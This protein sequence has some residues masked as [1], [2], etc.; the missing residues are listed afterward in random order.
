M[1]KCHFSRALW[2]SAVSALLVFA[3]VRIPLEGDPPQ[4][5]VAELFDP[6]L[7]AQR[8][9]GGERQWS[10]IAQAMASPQPNINARSP[11]LTGLGDYT[12]KITTASLDAQAFFDQGL[13]LIYAFNPGEAA[14][15]FRSASDKDPTCAMC[16]W[17]E[18]LGLGGNLNGGMNQDNM[19][20]ALAAVKKA[21]ENAPHVTPH[22][23]ALIGALAE[24]YSADKT[25]KPQ[26]LDL[27]Y[28]DA[29]AKVYATYSDD[30]DI[31]D[32]SAD[33]AMQVRSDPWGNWWDRTRTHPTGYLARAITALEK[34]LARYPDHPGAIHLYIHAM[35]G[36]L[37]PERAEPYADKLS[38]L[39]PGAGHMV[40]MPAHIYF[41][42]GRYT[43][44]LATNVAAIKVDEAYLTADAAATNVYRYGLYAH[45]VQFAL[46][47]AD[48]AGDTDSAFAMVEK[49]KAFVTQSGASQQRDGISAVAIYPVVAFGSPDEMLALPEPAADLPY[50]QG[51]WHYAR[52][53]AYA[54]KGDFRRAVK[55]ADAIAKARS[56]RN[57]KAF[58]KRF[59]FTSKLLGIAEHVVRARVA[60]AQGKWSDAADSLQKAATF[61]DEV[62]FA[63]DPP[64]WDFPVRQAW[65]VASWR[66]GKTAQAEEL[67]RQALL[68]AP[69]SGYAL[70]ALQ[71]ISRTA[72]DETAVA[73]YSKLLKKA[74]AGKTPPELDRL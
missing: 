33:A 50:A 58:G 68:E 46:A 3:P 5:D 61:Q 45:N 51:I 35:D 13:R 29:M 1:Q 43:D 74:W 15:S 72:G 30:P 47:S 18:A 14:A 65:G 62:A 27:A 12:Y 20:A 26:D 60:A 34:V 2:L 48:M 36:S 21:Q 57:A 9:C 70:Y 38:K 23:Q 7:I 32:L 8:L 52:G 11:R 55:E 40:H 71:E 66:A 56:D 41:N 69:N 25:I 19:P 63:R 37:W 22:E 44:S 59:G 42:I 6:R 49:I 4:S 16:C 28:A 54:Y 73:E 31:A 17:G 64:P 39:M 67:L 10:G 53:T 24:R